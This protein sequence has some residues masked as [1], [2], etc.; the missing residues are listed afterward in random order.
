M[1][2]TMMSFTWQ[3]QQQQR[4]RQQQQYS[5]CMWGPVTAL[6]M[7]AAANTFPAGKAGANTLP[8]AVSALQFH[9]QAV[10]VQTQVCQVNPTGVSDPTK[11][12]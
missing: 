6:M 7:S 1:F 3:Q 2:S 8:A 12:H 10:A 9:T 5:E 11:P 4:Q